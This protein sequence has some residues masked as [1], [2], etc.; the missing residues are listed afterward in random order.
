MI[1]TKLARLAL[2]FAL[3]I[4]LVAGY[5][6]QPAAASETA[7]SVQ[8]TNTAT[9]SYQDNSGN[10]YNSNSNTVTTTV[11]NAPTLTV[12]PQTAQ[13]VAPDDIVVDT[14]T[15]TNTGNASGN[16]AMASDSVITGSATLQGYVLNAAASGS[17]SVATPC[18]LAALN[19][20]LAALATTPINGTITIGVEYQVASN[21]STPG[22]VQTT[23]VANLTYPTTP[24]G[25]TSGNPGCAPAQTSGNVSANDTD[26]LLAEARLDQQKTASQPTLPSQPITWTV[27]SNDGGAFA[28]H[29]LKSAQ[30][31]LGAANPGILIT[32]KLPSFN[33]TLLGLQ[34]APTVTLNGAAAGATSKVYYTTD[35]TGATGWTTTYNA[36]AAMIGVFIYGG[37][38]GVELPS[39]PG[40]S[41]GAGHVTTAQVTI[42]YNTNQPTGPGSGSPNSVSNM[43]N[44]VI[45]GNPWATGTEPIVGPGVPMGTADSASAGALTGA[46]GP[47][48]NVTPSSGTT[49]PGGASNIAYSQAATQ[50]SVL[51]GPLDDPGATGSYPAAPNSGTAAA[52][53]NL[54]FTAVSFACANGAAINTA[55]FLCT[56]PAAGVVVPNTV[57]NNGNVADTFTLQGT[58]PAG[59]TVQLFN[60]TCPVPSGN[61]LPTCTVGTSITGV[62]SVGGTISGSMG[63]IAS[64]ASVNYVAVYK[65]ASGVAAFIGVDSPITVT[66]SQAETNNTHDDLYPGGAVEL[67]KT[68]TILSNGCPNESPG[69]PAGTVCPSGVIKYSVAYQN[70]A[71]A[72]VAPGGTNAGTEPAWALAGITTNAGTLAITEDGAANGNNWTTYTFGLNAAPVDTTGGTTYVYTPNIAFAHGTYPNITAGPT[73]FVATVGGLAFNLQPGASGTI[74]FNVTVQ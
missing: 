45:G 37:A 62:S 38:G 23:L 16:F 20:A 27:T 43:A 41:T 4:G 30:T 63:S 40:G 61:V 2:G 53:N 67:T 3:S 60:A 7:P 22:T 59:Y 9:A 68:V 66:G 44:S 26:S 11:Q 25:C 57:Q 1:A 72:T 6:M 31:L 47:L 21:A 5:A 52:T 28:A 49:P 8:I 50:V 14:Y 29:D 15:L 56:V 39:A 35:P 74:T 73:K 32:D 55:G 64:G 17:C 36:N 46:S 10:T 51:N 42:A 24:A 48:Q 12:T 70:T 19:T 65:A 69:P 33:S 18:A 13:N 34:A 71:P 58:A 54:D